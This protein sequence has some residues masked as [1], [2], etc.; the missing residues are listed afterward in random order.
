M[1]SSDVSFN[2]SQLEYSTHA[3]ASGL[4]FAPAAF[5]APKKRSAVD[6]RSDEGGANAVAWASVTANNTDDLMVQ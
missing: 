6:T 3:P 5:L 1:V 4:L 2:E